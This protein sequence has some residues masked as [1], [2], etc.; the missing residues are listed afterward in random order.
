MRRSRP[1]HPVP[2]ETPASETTVD[3]VVQTNQDQ[4]VE[5]DETVKARIT[6]GGGRLT[7]GTLSTLGSIRDLTGQRPVPLK[8]M[9]TGPAS[10]TVRCRVP[11]SSNWVVLRHP[12]PLT[13]GVVLETNHGSVVLKFAVPTS[14]RPVARAASTTRQVTVA[15]GQVQVRQRPDGRPLLG[16]AAAASRPAPPPD[17]Q[18]GSPQAAQS[19]SW[20]A[21]PTRPCFTAD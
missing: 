1:F 20:D 14:R 17:E 21:S 3:F 9:L 7:T 8:R 5:G 15:D 2:R 6:G 19:T 10:G 18:P 4:V 12:A 16:H 11:G 13:M